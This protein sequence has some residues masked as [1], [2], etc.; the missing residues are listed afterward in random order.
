[1][2][3]DL[4]AAE[5]LFFA[6]WNQLGAHRLDRFFR[7]YPLA[8]AV[9]LLA[10]FHRH[11][12]EHRFEVAAVRSGDAHVGRSL[13]D[14]EVGRVYVRHWPS[15]GDAVAQDVPHGSENAQVDGL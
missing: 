1:M 4:D 14:G 3:Y 10:D 15:D 2:S 11:I 5:T 12:E 9:A 8:L 7:H 6:R 13:G